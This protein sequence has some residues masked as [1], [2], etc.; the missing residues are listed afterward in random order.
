ML[1]FVLVFSFPWLFRSEDKI[2]IPSLSLDFVLV[3]VSL[4]VPLAESGA[5]NN[6]TAKLGLNI[7]TAIPLRNDHRRLNTRKRSMPDWITYITNITIILETFYFLTH[8]I[9]TC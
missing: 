2:F 4:V 8:F 9:G 5:C 3:L 1:F 7:N 6:A